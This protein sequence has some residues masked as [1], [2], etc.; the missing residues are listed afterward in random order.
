MM[1]IQLTQYAWFKPRRVIG[2]TL[3]VAILFAPFQLLAQGDGL[4]T[5]QITYGKDPDT[6]KWEE[7]PNPC[8][9]PPG[10]ETSPTLPTESASTGG[11]DG[12]ETIDTA[13]NG[14]AI[15]DNQSPPTTTTETPAT[16]GTDTTTPTTGTTETATTNTSPPTNPPTDGSADCPA[17][18][19]YAKP[20]ETSQKWYLFSTPCD[21]PDGW[22]NKI[23]ADV[24][25][26]AQNPTSENW[27]SFVTPCDVPADWTKTSY[28]KPENIKYKDCSKS[29]QAGYAESP[30]TANWYEFANLCDAPQNWNPTGVKPEKVEPFNPQIVD[31]PPTLTYAQH[32][33]SE[34]WYAF[35]TPCEVPATWEK[36]G[37]VQQE[38]TS[39]GESCEAFYA[40]YSADGHLNIPRVVSFDNWLF[41]DIGLLQV[42]G[43]GN[44]YFLFSFDIGSLPAPTAVTKQ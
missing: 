15:T 8:V 12:T 28:T 29:P 32:P 21:V 39:T 24:V 23:C 11:V 22:I 35:A 7:F 31:C 2:I 4:C 37:V 27:F 36:V 43:I 14:N 30:N 41:K 34:H 19:T 6:K 1:N 10:W 16:S 18:I 33:A 40:S 20:S 26:Y 5:A 9:V 17:Q 3:S 42:G 38:E 44:S 25:V 13:V